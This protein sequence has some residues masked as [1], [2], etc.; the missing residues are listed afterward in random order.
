MSISLILIVFSINS[1]LRLILVLTSSIYWRVST[2]INYVIDILNMP[3]D[4]ILKQDRNAPCDAFNINYAF[5]HTYC[6]II[7]FI[8]FRSNNK[9]LT[10]FRINFFLNFFS[11]SAI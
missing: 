8:T 5:L 3:D 11:T 7:S 10:S 1:V 4:W 6:L 2:T 9:D